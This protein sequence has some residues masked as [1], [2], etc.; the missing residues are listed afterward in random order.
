VSITC[1]DADDQYA[2]TS[3]VIIEQE[4]RKR[5]LSTP[6]GMISTAVLKYYTPPYSELREYQAAEGELKRISALR[7]GL[8]ER[9]ISAENPDVR[10][11][12]LQY[13]EVLLDM[14]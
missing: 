9:Q 4:L 3:I 10:H 12:L 14:M 5:L 7:K 11:A 1:S 2:F 6:C 13:Q 8:A